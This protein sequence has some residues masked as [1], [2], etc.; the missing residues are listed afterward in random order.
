MV[1]SCSF[2]AR[3]PFIAA[4]RRRHVPAQSRCD[5]DLAEDLAVLDQAQAVARLRERQH[6]VDYRL[7]PAAVDQR[8]QR[9]QVVVVEAV[10]PDHIELEAPDVAQVFLGIV[11][12]GCAAH[13]RLAAALEALERGNPGIAAGKVD[14]HVDTAVV[15]APFRLAV[16][17]DGP[18]GKIDV[19]VVDDV[20]GAQVLQPLHLFCAAGTGDHLGAHHPGQQHAAGA[21][22][23]ARAEVIACAGGAE[24]M[25]RLKDLGAD[26]VIDYKN[27]DF[28]RWAIEKY[29]KPQRRSYDGGVDVVVNFTGGDTWVPSLKCLKRG[30][31]LL[32]C[33]ATAGHDPKE[34]LRYIWSFE[35]NVI[36]SNSFYADRSS[37]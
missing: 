1:S 15:A 14:D 19:L 18:P 25:Q 3:S 12:R 6:L 16:L 31:K 24:K 35:L 23:S 29:G 21:D 26:H 28:S 5:H 33:G 30:G 20:I 8:H 2:I 32:V 37:S 13:Q 7:D 27:V 22:T 9:R 17:F 10:R 4:G 36:G 11:P 34:D